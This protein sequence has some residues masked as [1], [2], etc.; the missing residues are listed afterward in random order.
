[1]K[2]RDPKR[3]ALSFLRFQRAQRRPFAQVILALGDSCDGGSVLA[4]DL[5][6]RSWRWERG[7]ADA[8]L[9]LCKDTTRIFAAGLGFVCALNPGDGQILFLTEMSGLPRALTLIPDESAAAWRVTERA[10]GRGS[11]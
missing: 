1:M 9:S 7:F 6:S 4:W 2:P 5:S 3:G 8:V 11:H 10:R